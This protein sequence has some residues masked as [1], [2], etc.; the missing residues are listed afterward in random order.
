[1]PARI[2]A[3]GSGLAGA[4]VWLLLTG[5]GLCFASVMVADSDWRKRLGKLGS[6]VLAPSI[7]VLVIGLVPHLVVP[8]GLVRL[9]SG[10]TGA[11]FPELAEYL[12]F[13]STKAGSGFLT[14]GL[15]GLG[16]GTAL[17]SAKRAIPPSED[18]ALD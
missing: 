18:E 2:G 3:I 5:A 12:R 11:S 7:I 4:S 1:M 10:A 17:V 13:I 9:P 14:A 16:V 8:G 6:R 15:I